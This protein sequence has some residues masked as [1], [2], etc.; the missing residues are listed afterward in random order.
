MPSISTGWA[1]EK[2]KQVQDNENDFII[3]ISGYRGVGKSTLMLQIADHLIEDNLFTIENLKKHNI[4]SRDELD[5]KLENFPE[6][7]VF[8]VDEGINLLFKREFFNRQ[9]NKIIKRFNTYRDK[10][11]CIFLLIPNFW[12]LDSSV[13]NS[14]MIKWWI[15]CYNRGNAYIY[16]PEEN[17]WNPDP[18]NQKTNFM[19]VR[20]GV[21]RYQTPNYLTNI[22]WRKLTDKQMANYKKVKAFKRRL[23]YKDTAA[24]MS[25]KQIIKQLLLKNERANPAEIARVIGTHKVYVYDIIKE[26]EEKVSN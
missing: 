2:I 17:E 5:E 21:K 6:K 1:A 19:A 9:Q 23:A 12:D 26:M 7:S 22:V 4:Y 24:E 16:Q 14:A 11:F 8:C 10:Y 20:K 15:H 18:W 13:R 3:V 25:K